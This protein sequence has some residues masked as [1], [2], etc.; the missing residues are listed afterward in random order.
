MKRLIEIHT[1]S[2]RSQ[3]VKLGKRPVIREIELSDNERV[4]DVEMEPQ[5]LASSDRKTVDW[6]WTLFIERTVEGG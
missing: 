4:V 3:R 5:R 1:I 6:T 2:G